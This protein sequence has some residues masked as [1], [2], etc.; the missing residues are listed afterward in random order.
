MA[1]SQRQDLF[2]ILLG[3]GIELHVGNL[4]RQAPRSME[5]DVPGEELPDPFFGARNPLQPLHRAI[6]H[7][8]GGRP[9][10]VHEQFLLA[11]EMVVDTAGLDVHAGSDLSQSRAVIP[12][13]VEQP[14]RHCDYSF[15]C[16][17]N[18]D[19]AF[20]GVHFRKA[21]AC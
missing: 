11:R 17:T 16:R 3:Q 12:L 4:R 18:L 5:L 1:V 7:V 19:S 21:N 10:D 2:E 20:L 15:V 14:G 6:Q 9:D 13:L 8:L